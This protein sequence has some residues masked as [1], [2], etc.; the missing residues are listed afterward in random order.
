MHNAVSMKVQRWRLFFMHEF[1]FEIRPQLVNMPELKARVG[2]GF[3]YRAGLNRKTVV[4]IVHYK[5]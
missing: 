4:K 2:V 1:N 5:D 3:N